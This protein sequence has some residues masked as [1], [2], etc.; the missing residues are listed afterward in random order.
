MAGLTLDACAHMLAMAP[1]HP[2]QKLIDTHP[3]NWFLGPVVSG[4]L[5]DSGLVLG[6]HEL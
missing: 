1:F 6:N 4:Q 5:L 2:G 3:G